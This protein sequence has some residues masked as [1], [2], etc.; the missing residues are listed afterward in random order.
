MRGLLN[1]N[2]AHDMVMF[3]YVVQT[4]NDKL[5][6]PKPEASHIVS[7]HMQQ[8]CPDLWA[9]VVAAFNAGDTCPADGHPTCSHPTVTE[10][11]EG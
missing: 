8:G 6:I 2:P 3:G 4:M 9:D 11:P 10:S 7:Q 5:G 1:G